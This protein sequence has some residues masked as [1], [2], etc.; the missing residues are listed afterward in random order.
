MRTEEIPR[1]AWT[2]T[3]NAFTAMHE[4]WL[5][6]LEVLNA[7]IG[8][9]MEIENLP[10]VGVTAGTID[11]DPE[12]TISAGNAADRHI[13]HTIRGARHVYIE[14]T[15]QGADAA[16]QIESDDETRTILRLRVARL[17]ETVDGF[18]RV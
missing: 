10:L 7:G 3:F 15:D 5:V 16:V 14:R 2:G 11:G 13:S 9:Q 4:G 12:V 8:A 1:D 6:S 17:P 18:V